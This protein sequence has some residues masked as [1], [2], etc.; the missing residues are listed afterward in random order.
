MSTLNTLGVV[1]VLAVL[2]AVPGVP[3]ALLVDRRRPVQVAP[4]LALAQFLGLGIV[5][6]IVVGL[7][8][9]DRF[10][11]PWLIGL[12]AVVTVGLWVAALRGSVTIRP[13]KATIAGGVMAAIFGA[14]VL[15]R[16]DPIYFIFQTADF[17]EYVNRANRI[18]AGGQ[19]GEW[20]LS[21]FSA[22]LAVPSLVFGSIHT[23]DAMPLLGLLLV[24][25]VAATSHRMGFSPWITVT[26]AFIAAFHIVPVWFSEFPVSEMLSAVLLIGMLLVLATAISEGSSA[27][28]LSAGAFGFLLAIARA[29]AVLLAP[30]V[31]LAA[32]AAIVLLAKEAAKTTERFIG[33]FFV[34]SA[35]GFFYDLTFSYPYF[36]DHQLGFFLPESVLGH[37]DRLRNPL[38]F[39][40]L[41]VGAGA[42]LWALVVVAR[43]IAKH[44]SLARVLS[45]ATPLALLGGL[46]LFIA[47]RAATGAYESPGGKIMILGSLLVVLTV[48]GIVTGAFHFSPAHPERHVVYWIAA[49]AVI[50]FTA[51]QSVR[52]DL[53]NNDVAPYYLYWQRYYLSEIFPLALLLALGPLEWVTAGVGR[54]FDATSRWR[55]LAPIAVAVTV[56]VVVGAEAARPNLAVASGSMFSDSYETIAELDQMTS[57]PDDAPI[58]YLGS[59]DL[60]EGWFWLNTARLVALPLAETFGRRVVGNEGSREPDL[61]PT[62]EQLVEL[63]DELDEGRVFVVTDGATVPDAE[64]L[65]AAGWVVAVVGSVDLTIER[66]PWLPDTGLGDQRYV[67]TTLDLMVFEVTR[68]GSSE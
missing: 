55:K 30:V 33:A 66:L 62:D 6:A 39:A 12:V 49:A 38:V 43:W 25:G 23:V 67:S 11:L 45:T 5:L 51:L 64:A 15:L 52:V 37:A 3:A 61:R 32:V 50:A 8:H 16:T 35:A 46:I 17:G 1:A 26:V 60:P 40:T 24:A 54:L 18:A 7:V 31:I 22:T 56:M 13:P 2:L 34:A 44:E 28:A 41:A 36:V 53:P 63:L 14:A 27:A 29:N 20:F 68:Q 9:G 59:N 4:T 58:I 19:F 47:R 65:A 10:A 48:A 42:A 57:N 21:L